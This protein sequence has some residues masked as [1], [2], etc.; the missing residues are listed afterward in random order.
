MKFNIKHIKDLLK[1]KPEQTLPPELDW[2]NMK[3]GILDK[4][5]AMQ[6]EEASIASNQHQSNRKIVWYV[7]LMGA[8]LSGSVLTYYLLEENKPN[9]FTRERIEQERNPLQNSDPQQEVVSAQTSR[10]SNQSI[11]NVESPNS[12]PSNQLYSPD[13]TPKERASDNKKQTS[14]ANSV[15]LPLSNQPSMENTGQLMIPIKEGRQAMTRHDNKPVLS[16]IE[17]TSRGFSFEHPLGQV[18]H[19][20]IPADSTKHLLNKHPELPIKAESSR[21]KSLLL[22]GGIGFWNEGTDAIE[23][24]AYETPLASFQIQGHYV[25]ALSTRTFFMAGV[26]YQQLESKSEFNKTIDNY[27]VTIENA[28]VSVIRNTITG[29]TTPVRE[30]VSRQVQ[31]EH[32]FRHYNRISMLKLSTAFGRS[33]PFKSFQTSA[34]VGASVNTFTHQQGRSYFRDE[35][36]SYDGSQTALYDN[37]YAIDGLLG[38]RAGIPLNAR[39]AITAGLQLQRSLMNWSSRPDLNAY[40]TIINLQMGLSFSP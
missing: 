10:P 20:M 39:I 32:H 9:P 40:P 21:N 4:M 38:V 34:Y 13:H 31:A 5:K 27:P 17:I 16:A 2:S 24:K 30:N 3:D 6:E 7:L 33:W 12:T 29:E 22:E 15:S 14:A 18:I 19:R 28:V 35:I 26:Q 23:R 1:D 25:Q 11:N 8:L 37:R 36:I